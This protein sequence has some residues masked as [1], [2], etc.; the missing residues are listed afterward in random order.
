MVY[1]AGLI[2]MREFSYIIAMIGTLALL[3]SGAAWWNVSR[4]PQLQPFG[5]RLEQDTRGANSA[6]LALVVA[7]G[8]S[9]VAA[10]LAI[11]AWMF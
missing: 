3:V 8:F 11:F 1:L 10:V 5:R 9:L 7:F 4:R 6:A 2:K